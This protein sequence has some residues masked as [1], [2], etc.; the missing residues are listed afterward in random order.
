MK[1][2][3]VPRSWFDETG[4]RFDSNP[5][6]G[7]AIETRVEINSCPY[8]KQR[9][10]ELTRGGY[11]GIVHAGRIKRHWVDDPEY[12][13]PF[14]SGRDILQFDYSNLRLIRKKS[15]IDNP[16]LKLSSGA[17]LITRAGTVGKMAYARPDMEGL[18][19]TE[20]VLRVVPDEDKIHS[21]Y[22]YAYLNS[23]YGIPL[24]LAGTYGAI[25]Q[26]IEPPHICDLPVPRLGARVEQ[27]IHELVEKAANNLSEY[28]E[29]INEASSLVFTTLGLE[30]ISAYDWRSNKK[31]DFGFVVQSSNLE[32]MRGWNHSERLSSLKQNIRSVRHSELKDVI[33]LDWLRWR[34]MFKRIDADKEHGI[35]VM[36]QKTLFQ[37]FPEGRWVSKEYLLNHSPRFKVPDETILIAKQGT[38][39]EQEV[40]CRSEFITGER[41]LERA[42]SDHCM[43][44]VAIPEKI[45][46][47]Y[48]FAFLRSQTGFRLLRGLSEGSKQQDLHWRMVP[49]LPI[50]RCGGDKEK[51]IG[52]KV[53]KAYRLKNE[54]IQLFTQARNKVEETIEGAK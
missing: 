12:G 9:L 26:H 17:T 52:D 22:L 27:A 30:N 45:D 2:K 11:S 1:I 49:T 16:K 25:I 36:T 19:C 51:E 40:Y 29:L 8:P 47:G 23:K 41:T 4:L 50:P 14:L 3:T 46:A 15:A 34:V 6:I 32:I 42:Y 37:L 5:Y 38:L 53:R 24:I 31:K 10:D 54:A 35:E 20:D 48:L 28:Q 18:A 44:V 13:L 39:G 43:R 7:G 21:G 33:D